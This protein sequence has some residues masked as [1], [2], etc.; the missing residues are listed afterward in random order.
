[1]RAERKNTT[2]IS[3]GTNLQYKGIVPRI[4]KKSIV[5]RKRRLDEI[6]S[7]RTEEEDSDGGEA[8]ED[9]ISSGKSSECSVGDD[10]QRLTRA[11]TT[12]GKRTLNL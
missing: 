3:D 10:R 5:F 4:A 9:D 12:T 11:M 1:V 2:G 8:F 7:K 6:L